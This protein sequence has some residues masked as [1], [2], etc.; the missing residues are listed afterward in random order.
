MEYCFELL[1]S[2]LKKK[3]EKN[4]VVV[5][6]DKISL[7]E[8]KPVGFKRTNI[9]SATKNARQKTTWDF[10]QLTSWNSNNCH[11]KTHI[12]VMFL[13]GF[14]NMQCIHLAITTSAIHTN[15]LR[16]R[17]NV[18]SRSFFASP[19]VVTTSLKLKGV[20]DLYMHPQI[21]QNLRA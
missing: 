11:L 1:H 21:C 4:N 17:L 20:N 13:W 18:A 15:S 16:C 9:I 19:T 7:T 2:L 5:V 14:F 12:T 6:R 10:Q 3:N 8:L